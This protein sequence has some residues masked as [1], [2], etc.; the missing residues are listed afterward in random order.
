MNDENQIPAVKIGP[1]DSEAPEKFE[2]IKKFLCNVIPYPIEVEHIGSTAVVGLG[3][4]GVIDI[5]IITKQEFMQKTVESLESAGYKFNPE[6]GF[7]TFPEKFF[8]SG[9]YI[10]NEKE[11]HV[12]FHITFSGSKEHKEKLLFRDYLRRH[13]EEA[14]IY[15]LLK[16]RW[17]MEADSEPSKYT[18]LKTSYIDEV[19]EKARREQVIRCNC[20]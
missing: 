20:V 2:A 8:I 7:G 3:G 13:P 1:Y 6:V 12:H 9:P 10:Y 17:S 18:E 16:K 14:E 5:L 4:K 11:L 19:L 15:F